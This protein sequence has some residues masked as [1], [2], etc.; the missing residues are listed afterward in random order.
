MA[1][2][3]LKE[4]GQILSC[5]CNDNRLVQSFAIDSRHVSPGALFFA[6]KGEKV[7]GHQF[8]EEAA[9]KGAI[10]SVVDRKYSGPSFG[11]VLFPVPKVKE[12]LHSMAK[13]DFSSRAEKVIA[14]TGSMGKTTTKEFLATLL[15]EKYRVAKTPGNYNTQVTVPLTLL[16]L[17]GEYDVIVLEMGMGRLGE[18]ARLVSIAP[19]D[20]AIVTKIAPA[21]MESFKGGLEAIAKAK[22]EIFTHPKTHLG[23][24]SSQ[25]SRYRDVLYGGG[26]PKWIYGWK[27][28]L[29]DVRE[30]DFVM[31][32]KKGALF[33]NDSPPITLSFEGDHLKENFLAAAS[34]ARAM[35]LSWNDIQNGAKKCTPYPLRFQKIERDGI[36]FIQ[37]SYNANPDSMT[38]AMKNLPRPN[39]GGKMI[40]ILGSMPDLGNTSLKYH[41]QIGENA[42][43]HFDEIFCIGDDAKEIQAGFSAKG[44]SASHFSNLASIKTKLFDLAKPGDVVLIKGQNALKLWE[45]LE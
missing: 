28:E 34:A 40:G 5:D 13:L 20:I 27:K 44:K 29:P 26:M 7:D 2:K 4:I 21:G 10:A 24:I 17:E 8:L 33:I 43:N 32:E 14:V 38:I 3:S 1:Q 19:P 37:D 16:N 41:R 23:I 35:G 39:P 30:A 36:I 12:A 11:L 6:L 18:I 31:E 42:A 45:I 22:S 15:E 9:Q 25:A